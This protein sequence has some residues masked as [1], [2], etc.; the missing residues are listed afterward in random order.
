MRL[1]CNWSQSCI[2][3]LL[4]HCFHPA[5]TF[6]FCFLL[7]QHAFAIFRCWF[8]F[9]L[10]CYCVDL[11]SDYSIT[12][13]CHQPDQFFISYALFNT[14]GH[15]EHRHR[16]ETKKHKTNV[17]LR[18]CGMTLSLY[19]VIALLRHRAITLCCYCFTV[20]LRYCV[21]PAYLVTCA[22]SQS[23]SLI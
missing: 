14:P 18:C 7:E 22:S 6:L 11:F 15:F 21:I 17:F 20:M 12:L 10:L 4:P 2:I 13:L 8:V 19:V 9:V 3:A 5:S 1:Y 23:R 16:R